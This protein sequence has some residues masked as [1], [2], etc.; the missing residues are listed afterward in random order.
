MRLTSSV[1]EQMMA[2]FDNF[3]NL[4]K[5]KIWLKKV[6]KSAICFEQVQRFI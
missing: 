3:Y 4:L 2:R 1:M 6:P 5:V